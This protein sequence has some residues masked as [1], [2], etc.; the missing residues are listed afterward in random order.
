M[1]HVLR[2]PALNGIYLDLEVPYQ[3]IPAGLRADLRRMARPCEFLIFQ[4]QSEEEEERKEEEVKFIHFSNLD[5]VGPAKRV[6][7]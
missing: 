7:V 6:T 4:A 1:L 2:N 5:R 3:E